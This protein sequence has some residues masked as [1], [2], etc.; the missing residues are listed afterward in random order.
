MI[1]IFKGMEQNKNIQNRFQ[2]LARYKMNPGSMQIYWEYS[3]WRQ[4]CI[5]GMN[6]REQEQEYAKLLSLFV[7]VQ[8]FKEY[9][10]VV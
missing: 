2:L 1:I 10:I 7:L 3:I 9:L 6:G 8:C 5:V 4:L